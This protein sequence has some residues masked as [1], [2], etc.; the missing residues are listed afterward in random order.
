M[1]P[2]EELE[3]L[4]QAQ[5]LQISNQSLQIEKL[6]QDLRDYQ[7][8]PGHGHWL[9][10]QLKLNKQRLYGRSSEGS[11]GLQ[12]ALL[13]EAECEPLPN[14]DT[15]T[16]DEEILVIQ[17]R[18]KK[19]NGRKI[20]TNRLPRERCIRDLSADEKICGCGWAMEKIDEDVTEQIDYV[21][22]LFKV[23][24][25]VTPKYACRPCH[26]IKAASKP[27]ISPIQKSMATAGSLG[28][29]GGRALWFQ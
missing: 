7:K 10:E 18:S 28:R 29:P 19:R 14:A 9:E 25:H 6:Q 2:L 22:A 15:D 13:D 27:E 1:T 4:V 20:D 12:L 5:S 24:E 17:R 3:N 26:Q 21:P 23:I 16:L 11:E 8:V